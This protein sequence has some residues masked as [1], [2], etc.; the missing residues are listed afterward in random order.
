MKRPFA[1]WKTVAATF[2][3]AVIFYA[4]AWSW[5]KQRQTGKGPWQ[6]DFATNS[7]GLPQLTIAEPQLGISNVT[8][9]FAGEQLAPTNGT[10]AVSFAKP[11]MRVPFCQVIYDDLMFQPGVVTLDCFGHVVEMAPRALGLNGAGQPWTNGA[12]HVL[13]PT[14]KMPEEARKKLKGGYRIT[15]PQNPNPKEAPN[16]K[17]Q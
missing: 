14:N 11:R 10:G 7:A 12:M 17:H 15:K 3:L 2:V 5:M 9:Q 4:L 6:V 13:S 8:V 1:T 16:P